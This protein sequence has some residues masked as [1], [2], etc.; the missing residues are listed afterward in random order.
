MLKYSRLHGSCA[1]NVTF[2]FKWQIFG[3]RRDRPY[4][5]KCLMNLAKIHRTCSIDA[6]RPLRWFPVIMYLFWFEKLRL[7]VDNG[8]RL[9]SILW[10]CEVSEAGCSFA[11]ASHRGA[12]GKQILSWN[13]HVSQKLSVESSSENEEHVL[14]IWALSPQH[15]RYG[16]CWKCKHRGPASLQQIMCPSHLLSSVSAPSPSSML[17]D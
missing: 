12:E 6:V 13:P 10:N 3:I 8:Y 5:H 4:W 1:Y 16:I 17:R 9:H 7:W 14:S 11:S 2:W 15:Q